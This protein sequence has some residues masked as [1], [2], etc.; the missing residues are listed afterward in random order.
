MQFLEFLG[1]PGVGKTY[2]L[3]NLRKYSSDLKLK[4]KFFVFEK[5]TKTSIFVKTFYIVLA[6]FLFINTSYIKKII[7]FFKNFYKPKKSEIISIRTFSILFNTI[8]LVSIIR[9]SSLFR[10]NKN[11]FIDQ[12]FFQIL[13]SIIY[14]M[15]LKNINT[16]KSLIKNWLSI[17]LSL[18]KN[19]YVIYFESED[20]IILKRLKYRNGDSMIDRQENLK[21]LKIYKDIFDQILAFLVKE[22]ENYPNIFLKS[23][24]SFKSNI[25]LL[26]L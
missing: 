19:I 6:S 18:K 17:P 15:D 9:V 13:F 4:N 20:Q 24:T 10:N 2:T 22:N 26:K 25:D 16:N 8:F 14:E 21:N 12:G 23:I 3:R 5:R 7:I 11:I 1:M